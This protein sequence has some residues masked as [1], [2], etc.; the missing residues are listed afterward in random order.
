MR[1][2]RL[3]PDLLR[4]PQD[5]DAVRQ[6]PRDA[7]EAGID[8][9]RLQD[10]LLLVGRRVHEGRD[11]VGERA[12]LLDALDRRDQLLGRL[13]Q[14]L[15]SLERLPLEVDEARLDLVGRRRRLGDPD[16]RPRRKTASR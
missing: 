2:P 7:V 11:H 4:Q 8:V 13:R 12:G 9:D 3:P 14:E 5:L 10:L 15:Q 16:A 1:G 6:K